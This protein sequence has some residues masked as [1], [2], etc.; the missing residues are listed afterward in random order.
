MKRVV[1][2]VNELRRCIFDKP[3]KSIQFLNG[4]LLI[5][6]GLV[7]LLNGTALKTQKFYGNFDLIGPTWVWIFVLCLGIIQLNAL[8]KDTLES[9]ILSA[10]VLK[11]SSLIWCVLAITFGSDYPPLSTAFFN[12]LSLSGITL[13]ASYELEVQNN[14]ELLI[15]EEIRK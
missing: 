6:F 10:I 14:Y 3:T 8:R 2:K 13:L 4:M 9:N 5:L 7:F 11:I 15:R 1:N 12:Y